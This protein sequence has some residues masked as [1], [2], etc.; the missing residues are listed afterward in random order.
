MQLIKK[1]KILAQ[2]N[3]EEETVHTA[4]STLNGN[5]YKISSHNMINTQALKT[6][7]ET[8]STKFNTPTL[9]KSFLI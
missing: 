2:K 9:I 8:S 4:A 1:K 3:H 6:I 5:T 7:F